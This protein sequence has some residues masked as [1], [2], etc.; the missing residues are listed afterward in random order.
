MA[1]HAAE[2]EVFRQLIGF[3]LGNPTDK[4][5]EC[6]FLFAPN[7]VSNASAM[8]LGDR[9]ALTAGHAVVL[10]LPY[11]LSVPVARITEVTNANSF[12]AQPIPEPSVDLAL[13]ELSGFPQLCGIRVATD[14]ELHQAGSVQLCGFGS[15]DC[16]DL[17]MAGVRRLSKPFPLLEDPRALGVDIAPTEFAVRNTSANPLVCDSDSGGGALIIA[18]DGSLKLAGIIIDG[19]SSPTTGAPIGVRCIRLPA[20]LDWIRRVTGLIDL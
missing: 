9:W 1:E 3:V 19:L 18:S 11:Q 14:Q 7:S 6:G 2:A 5:P 17:S 4:V 13:L 20:F 15:N 10:D 8:F 12:D 16:E